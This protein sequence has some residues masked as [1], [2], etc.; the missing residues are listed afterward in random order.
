MTNSDI[1][2]A[3]LNKAIS[4]RIP[5]AN[6]KLTVLP[7]CPAISLW[8]LD[9][10]YPQWKLTNDQASHIM[11]NPPFWSFCWASGQVLAA[12]LLNNPELVKGKTLADF[13]A[14]S[15]VVSIAALLAGA[16]SVVAC[17][18]DPVARLACEA[19]A[20]INGVEL[21]TVESLEATPEANI[22]T[23]ADVFY[24]REN[25][26]L[27]RDMRNKFDTLMV[28]DSRLKQQELQQS[29]LAMFTLMDSFQSYTVPDLAESSEFN[30]VNLYTHKVNSLGSES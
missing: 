8:L 5:D 19:N 16:K 20:Q 28:A 30:S 10:D 26:P 13:G 24:D 17:D 11:A 4:E 9:A 2:P 27:L 18:S 14:G 21:A 23:V 12:Y 7:Q 6:L 3:E 15:G 22:V 1:K 25:L 29:P